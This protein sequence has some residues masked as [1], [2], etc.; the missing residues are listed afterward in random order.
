MLIFFCTKD[1]LTFG[2]FRDERSSFFSRSALLRFGCGRKRV[3]VCL[4]V[5]LLVLLFGV[6]L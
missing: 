1:W 2:V 5:C 4:F 3:F 6:M